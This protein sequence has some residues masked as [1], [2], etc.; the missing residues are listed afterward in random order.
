MSQ[1]SITEETSASQ[2]SEGLV[3]SDVSLELGDGEQRVRVLDHVNLHVANGEFAAV[4]GPSGSG[5]SSLLAVAGALSLPDSGSVKLGGRELITATKRQRAKYRLKDVGFVF[6]SGNL[7]P[8]LTAADQLR[9]VN[10][11]AKGPRNFDPMPLLAAVGMEHRAKHRPGQ[12]SGGERQRVGIARAM[13]TKPAVMLLDEPTATLDSARSREVVELLA[14]RAREMG[15]ATVMVTH[16][17]EM[18][19]LCD[20]VYGMNDGALSSQ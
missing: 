2:L 8:S 17:R 20:T 9:M 4:V 18:L 1:L 10:R 19:D 5:K 13:V 14:Q 12:L 6:Q 3:L 16:D 7:I 15:I 11:L